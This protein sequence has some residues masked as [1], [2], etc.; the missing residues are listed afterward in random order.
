MTD[1][2]Y[3]PLQDDATQEL[4]DRLTDSDLESL[5]TALRQLGYPGWLR[6][7]CR[8]Y[9][10]CAELLSATAAERTRHLAQH[11][12]KDALLL[13]FGA[14]WL[15]QFAYATREEFQH[16]N[17]MDARDGRSRRTARGLVVASGLSALLEQQI[18]WP[19]P[20]PSPFAQR[21]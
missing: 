8:R 3:N 10:E 18:G 5:C 15:A 17:L 7:F 4:L 1:S 16:P 21:S 20:P 19:F 13:Q 2:T 6:W 9:S 11:S 12:A 14:I